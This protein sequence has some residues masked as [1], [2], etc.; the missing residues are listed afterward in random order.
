[1]N[2]AFSISRNEA[3]NI[4]RVLCVALALFAT[5]LPARAQQENIGPMVYTVGTTWR[6]LPA[7]RDWGYVLWLGND[8][9]L[10]NGQ[11][12]AIYAKPGDASSASPYQR[13][14][15][16][17][18]QSDTH[19][20]EP[21]LQRAAA[22]GEDLAKL[23][24]DIDALFG[25]LV[26]ANLTRA[27]KISAIIRGVMGDEQHYGRLMLLARTH[28]S[29]A[30]S[31][32]VA[33]ADVI[34]PGL[35][36]FEIRQ[37]N[38]GTQQDVAVIGRV[39]VQA[40]APT[41]LSSPGAPVQVPMMAARGDLNIQLRWATPDGLRRLGLLQH[42]YDVFRVRKEYAEAPGRNWHV[43]PPSPDV[44]N[45]AI[46][47]TAAVRRLNKLP[48]LTSKLFTAA[49]VG[50]FAADPKS[51]F[52]VDTDDR[53]LP[54]YVPTD[55][56]NGSRFYYFAAA[57]DLLG[58]DGDLSPGTLV[59][60]CDQ[61]PPHTL[62]DVEV[63]NDYV[64][65]GGTPKHHLR[66]IWQQASNSPPAEE[67]IQRYW[68]Y[69][70]TNS[71]ELLAKQSNNLANLI[72]IVS[73]NV[74]NLKNSYL[75]N[76]AGSPN[77]NNAIGK[78]F[79]YTVRAE[80][81]G[82]CGGNLSPHSAPVPGVLR[83]RVGPLAPG[84]SVRPKC[85]E[86]EISMLHAGTNDSG[87]IGLYSFTVHGIRVT[88]AI[89]WIEM[90][91]EVRPAQQTNVLESF[92]GGVRYF[93]PESITNNWSFAVE[94]SHAGD[95]VWI[96]AR[97]GSSDG[98]VSAWKPISQPLFL[99]RGSR[100]DFNAVATMSRAKTDDCGRHYPV[101]PG[102]ND[103]N[104]LDIQVIPTPTTREMRLYRRVDDG[105]LTF[106]CQ[107]TNPPPP[108]ILLPF[109]CQDDSFPSSA[110][111]ICY[112]AQ[113]FD[114]HG[115]A[116]P[117]VRL[118]CII[119]VSPVELPRPML[120]PITPIGTDVSP[121]MVLKWFCPPAG[122]ERFEV[123]IA[124]TPEQLGADPALGLLVPTGEIQSHLIPKTN[125]NPDGPPI[126]LQLFHFKIF[127]TP[128]ITAANKIDSDHD[129]VPDF[130]EVA[131][132]LDPVQSGADSDGDGYSDLEEL[133][134]GTN[135]LDKF[136]A[137]TNFPHADFKQVFDLFTTLRVINAVGNSTLS[138]TG[139]VVRAFG[140]DG[141]SFVQGETTNLLLAPVGVTNPVARMF[142]I[143]PTAGESLIS[144]STD[145]HF[146]LNVGGDTRVGREL[147][148]IV[149]V[150]RL[151]LPTLPPGNLNLGG[152]AD[153][154]WIAAVANII[155]NLPRT[156]LIGDLTWRDTLAA[157]LFEAKVAEI[158][159]ARGTNFGTNLTLFP[160]RLA[161]AG[162]DQITAPELLALE[163]YAGPGLPGYKLTN[164][165]AH[166]LNSIR[167]NNSADVNQLRALTALIYQ[168]SAAYNNTN[169][170]TLK[171][172]FDELRYFLEH[173][174]LDS[175]YLMFYGGGINLASAWLGASN[176][177][178]TVPT[179]AH[180]QSCH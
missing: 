94:D 27:E 129:G 49:D 77:T 124:G 102:S 151:V 145:Q 15:I 22:I 142:L 127:R 37:F 123:G 56:T 179:K 87:T 33:H 26:P 42:G 134:R 2:E 153:E 165:F 143:Q 148:G 69:R 138:K 139:V 154:A 17:S 52:I 113:L 161:D 170:A 97:C 32:V 175:G 39:T 36:T 85:F 67:K 118:G 24:I 135:P 13:I 47:S 75:D 126:Q 19:V 120:S 141:S 93:T 99:T 59:M 116:S 155:T 71:N 111:E 131:R 34:P 172:P 73:H 92:S 160:F 130:V 133:I 101:N 132:G 147:I 88:T 6:E 25:K 14:S 163:S 23:E 70:W 117:L 152:G 30:M 150:P 10:L 125:P 53:G 100:V 178:A 105:P 95:W 55:F 45:S 31:L 91:A 162:R 140:L 1:M 107:K 81:S 44:I 21:L 159:I 79:W 164:A 61:L 173:G 115:N 8:T 158:L 51:M 48:L 156:R 104:P 20:I 109:L 7:N 83:D 174:A 4:A 38:K 167:T 54:N 169:P 29:V 82:A 28:P 57:R 68:I 106:I 35:T 41:K 74:L 66:V 40:N 46:A 119:L 89:Q 80:D 76:G 90:R 114:E 128:R 43:T 136:N 96:Y 137:P 64:F 112:Y 78:V 18:A 166:F 176:L 108:F 16:V 144:Q 65:S 60:V 157:V 180:D 5:L 122:V 9:S 171:L 177:L 146:D 84:G 72:G 11:T 168:L 58:R 62:T 12:F 3:K 86:P 63:V 110:T 98:Q 103:I 121:A 149:P 50:N